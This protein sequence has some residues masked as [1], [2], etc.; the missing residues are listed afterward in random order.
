[1]FPLLVSAAA[2]VACNQTQAAN[3]GKILRASPMGID[4]I[5]LQW[6]KVGVAEKVELGRN[7]FF[8]PRLSADGTVSCATCHDPLSAFSLS[9]RFAT[10]VRGQVGHRKPPTIINAAYNRAQFWDARAATLEEQAA[11]PLMNP[12]EMGMS[13]ASV[14]SAL[15][16]IP[17]YAALFQKAFGDSAVSVARV[18]EAIATFERTVVSGNSAY[19]RFV[20][21]ERGALS[22][23]QSRGIGVFREAR[24]NACHEG[25][26]FSNGAL[27]NLGVGTDKPEADPG[28]FAITHEEQDRGRFKTPGLRDVSLRAP[29]MHDGSLNTLEEV[30]EFYDKGGIPNRNL[31]N[32]I[33]P[34]HLTA[35]NKADL[36]AF[37]RALNGE[38]WQDAAAPERLPQ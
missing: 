27:A 24:C 17:G 21:G 16:A 22:P 9:G 11:V 15:T 35:V 20:A 8:D 1:M 31:D 28:R 36:V 14:V 18:T 12:A 29:Y 6:G 19:D 34:L 4:P 10:G 25:K 37:L 26:A 7:L 33:R 3:P 32:R 30:V 5:P 2:T 13:P 38:G 23:E